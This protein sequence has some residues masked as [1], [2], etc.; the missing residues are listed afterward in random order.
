MS[1]SEARFTQSGGL[2]GLQAGAVRVTQDY[3]GAATVPGAPT[4]VTGTPSDGEV[5]LTW[6]AP[7]SD[8]GS[9][10]TGY[11][12]QYRPLWPSAVDV[13]SPARRFELDEG[14][15]TALNEAIS[16]ADGSLSGANRQWMTPGPGTATNVLEF[17]NQNVSTNAYANLGDIDSLVASSR[18]LSFV[19]GWK[20]TPS[21]PGTGDGLPEGLD[22]FGD[23]FG[24]GN[25]E[26]VDPEVDYVPFLL[27]EQNGSSM[28]IIRAG[29]FAFHY[30][31]LPPD[32]VR[33][34]LDE[35]TTCLT[36][37]TED[38]DA[39]DGNWHCFVW[40]ID[41]DANEFQ[42][43]MDGI[44]RPLEV[45]NTTA[46]NIEPIANWNVELLLGQAN[47]DNGPDPQNSFGSHGAVSRFAILPMR[48]TTAQ[49]AQV[50]NAMLATWT[51][52]SEPTSTAVT[53][54]G[55][56]NDV[57]YDFRVAAVN[58]VGTGSYSAASA[59]ET[60]TAPAFAKYR[61]F[62][63]TTDVIDWTLGNTAGV[64]SN[65]QTMVAV[66][67]IVAEPPAEGTGTLVQTPGFD[68]VGW[69]YTTGMGWAYLDNAV[70]V[71]V[72]RRTFVGE[73][74]LMAFR[75]RPSAAALW[76]RAVH[77]T[78]W[79]TPTHT[80]A[81]DIAQLVPGRGR[82]RVSSRWARHSTST[83]SAS[84]GSPPSSPTPRSTTWSTVSPPF[85][86]PPAS[87]TCGWSARPPLLIL[88]ALRR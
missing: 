40:A 1:I 33:N 49:A 38:I 88:L 60:P 54:T 37:I 28:A 46:V 11:V 18:K 29:A 3:A 43:W 79:P 41:C 56:T 59:P 71:I 22:Q 63:G 75:S 74:S 5:A 48:P 23:L 6:T 72:P 42:V 21:P 36:A 9:A 67:R 19:F 86:P 51:T 57:D 70:M 52:F 2:R 32:P 55:L 35:Y 47:H 50:S 16:N 83:S 7:A 66:M 15:G 80:P 87:P 27:C 4:A 68:P 25:T 14:T 81:T 12:V 85:K 76:S 24:G 64:T 30:G 65:P 78:S 31:N 17:T 8:G 77:S 26:L 44:D 45:L 82:R 73:W 53:V 39:N 62:N 10:I 13:M 84:P 69:V 61:T 34:D 58:V 20:K